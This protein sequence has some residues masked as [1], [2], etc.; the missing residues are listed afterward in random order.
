LVFWLELDDTLVLIAS[1]RVGVTIRLMLHT[2]TLLHK[3][4]CAAVPS[5]WLVMLTSS[6]VAFSDCVRAR[7]PVA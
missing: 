7:G 4:D 1:E 6:W 2:R 5:C 3:V